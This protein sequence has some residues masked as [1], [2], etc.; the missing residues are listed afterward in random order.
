MSD[1][2]ARIGV[3][4][5][6]RCPHAKAGDPCVLPPGVRYCL[7]YSDVHREPVGDVAV[8]GGQ[9]VWS[10]RVDGRPRGTWTFVA[11]LRQG[12]VRAP[13]ELADDPELRETVEGGR[14]YYVVRGPRDQRYEVAAGAL[15]EAA[16]E[17]REYV[18]ATPSAHP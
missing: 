6:V 3:R 8:R 9:I 2:P 10:V 12:A 17:R 13:V 1:F 4:V 16:A 15:V 14:A 7:C 11:L 5:G 18:D